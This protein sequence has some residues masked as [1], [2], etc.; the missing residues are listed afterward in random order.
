MP[1]IQVIQ[2]YRENE[3]DPKSPIK[4]RLVPLDAEEVNALSIKS[5]V[6]RVLKT[7]RKLPFR[8]RFLSEAGK[9]L[10]EPQVWYQNQHHAERSAKRRVARFLK[11]GGWFDPAVQQNQE[12]LYK[13]FEP[14]TA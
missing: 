6:V 11:T 9:L 5:V 8:L 3:E 1:Q 14:Q 12:A 13:S 10:F 7:D 4:K 2:R